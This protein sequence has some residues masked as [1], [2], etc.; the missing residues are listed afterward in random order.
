MISK[1]HNTQ[2]IHKHSRLTEHSFQY[3]LNLLQAIVATSLE[4]TNFQNQMLYDSYWNERNKM[5]Q[6]IGEQQLNERKLFHGTKHN[7][8][9]SIQIQGFRKEFNTIPF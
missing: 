9:D 3:T 7:V 4:K 6:L 1:T 2:A 5:V 8:M